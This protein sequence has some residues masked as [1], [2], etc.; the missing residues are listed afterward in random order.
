MGLSVGPDMSNASALL[1]RGS[2]SKNA[3]LAAFISA[4][5]L[6]R[7]YREERVARL[8]ARLV[9]PRDTDSPATGHH[10]DGPTS[11]AAAA[12]ATSSTPVDR[13]EGDAEA[14]PGSLARLID[15]TT[16]TIVAKDAHLGVL[17][18]NKAF[19]HALDTTPRELAGK[20]VL[21]RGFLLPRDHQDAASSVRGNDIDERAT[22]DGTTLHR[23]I[24]VQDLSA[25]R[26]VFDLVIVPIRDGRDAVV[27]ILSAA[28]DATDLTNTL[29]EL[30]RKDRALARAA[31][32]IRG[33]SR[34]L[35]DIREEERVRISREIHDDLGQRLTAINLTLHWLSGRTG[36]DPEQLRSSILDVV[37]MNTDLISAVQTIAN[38]LRP[39][40]LDDG[41]LEAAL[42]WLITGL[43]R[44][45]GPAFTLNYETT[46]PDPESRVCVGLFR[47]AQ[48]CV[49]NVLRHADA[50]NVT[51]TVSNTHD[52]RLLFVCDDDGVGIN[53]ATLAADPGLGLIGMRERVAQIGGC[54]SI[55]G[56]REGGTRVRIMVP[57]SPGK[58]WSG[59]AEDD[60]C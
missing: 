45:G 38:R 44:R 2:V 21:R 24:V 5:R 22:L 54:F 53:S 39:A 10:D 31:A 3:I 40:I 20:R 30:E 23:E 1:S 14:N 11:R 50:R 34:R 9:A 13:T 37:K 60:D 42:R 15:A 7:T 29:R 49:S 43:G 33:L 32:E 57:C 47:V 56:G 41:G 8:H 52:G 6:L 35:A 12:V 18:C 27:G 28:S 46:L 58:E 59:V 17:I 55:G 51:L 19:A 4:S 48:E 16:E 25:R 26:R 36:G